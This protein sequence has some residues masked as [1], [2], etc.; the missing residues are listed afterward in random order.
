M[1]DWYVSSVAYAAVPVFVPSVAYTVGQFVRPTAPSSIQGQYVWR[2]TTA[3]TASTEPSWA[4]GNSNNAAVTTGGA[5]FTCVSGQSTYGWSAASGNLWNMIWT[6]SFPRAVVGDRVFLSSDHNETQSFSPTYLLASTGFGVVEVISVNRAGSVPPVAADALSGAVISYNGGGNFLLDPIV[7]GY[8]QG[9][10]FT[11]AGTAGGLYLANSYA[12]AHYFK[13]CA[14][15]FTTSTTSAFLGANSPAQA[16]FDNTTVTFNNAGQRI[17]PAY[18][19]DLKWI[20]TPAAV[21]G[22]VPTVLFAE[23]GIS[24]GCP[25]TICRGVD[26]SAVTTTLCYNVGGNSTFLKAL[27]DSCRIAS[28]VARLGTAGYINT[29]DEVELVN[30]FDGTNILA[31]RHTPAGD[32]TTEFTITLSGG[33]QDNV[34][35]YSHKMIS[36][37]R[38]DPWTMTLDGFWLDVNNTALGSARTATVEIVSSASLNNNDI[39]LQVEYEGT[40]GSSLASFVS[41]LPSAL[42]TVAAVPSSSATWNSLPATPVTQ[43]LQATFTPLT[44]GRVR[45]RVRLGKPS[46]TVY[47]NPQVIIT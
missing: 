42:T 26:L 41:T 22:T 15:V 5:T 38:C 1:A 35:A 47:Y 36:S 13:N 17:I 7:N 39:S 20:N 21:L 43:H 2:C 11:I 33:A 37:T 27:F 30:C 18:S 3:G 23:G 14:F 19:L 45:A 29:A 24:Y 28:G 9:V 46:T 32:L 34:G 31:E 40:A 10:T 25:L 8:W 6:G 44:A 12:K 4:G 16:T